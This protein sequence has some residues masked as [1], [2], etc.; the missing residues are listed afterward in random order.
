MSN[1]NE[2]RAAFSATNCGVKVAFGARVDI[3]T[4]VKL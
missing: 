3:Q 1:R 4:F 2:A